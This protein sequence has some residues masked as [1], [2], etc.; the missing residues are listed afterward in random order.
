MDEGPWREPEAAPDAPVKRPFGVH[1]GLWEK[2]PCM[3]PLPCEIGD[4][5]QCTPVCSPTHV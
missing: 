5:G 4:F 3:S 1:S 2:T